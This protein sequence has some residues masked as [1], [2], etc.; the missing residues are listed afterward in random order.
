VPVEA[1]D[2]RRQPASRRHSAP[3][4]GTTNTSR[5]LDD[6]AAA[7]SGLRNQHLDLGLLVKIA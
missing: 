6:R 7:M 4:L 1:V 2:R 3:D 5:L